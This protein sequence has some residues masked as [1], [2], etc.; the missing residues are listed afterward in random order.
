[1]EVK[2]GNAVSII[3]C[4]MNVEFDAPEGY[5][6]PSSV[7]PS[8]QSVKVFFY[9]CNITILQNMLIVYVVVHFELVNWFALVS[10]IIMIN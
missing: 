4:D 5:V 2:P 8:A 9:F 6:E 10:F 1:M 3:E 7:K